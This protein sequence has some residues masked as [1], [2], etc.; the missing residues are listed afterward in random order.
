MVGKIQAFQNINILPS[1]SFSLSI[2]RDGIIPFNGFEWAEMPIP[3]L[4][5]PISN[6]GNIV[7][8]ASGYITDIYIISRCNGGS[9]NFTLSN[10]RNVNY[11]NTCDSPDYGF[12][13][14]DIIVQ[15]SALPIFYENVEVI[16]CFDHKNENN[17]TRTVK[18]SSEIY[19]QG[20]F[21]IQNTLYNLSGKS[22]QF[23][24]LPF[25]DYY[26][27]TKKN[28]D[29]SMVDMM[30]KLVKDEKIK[31]AS[32]YW[33]LLNGMFGS[34]IYDLNTSVLEKVANFG[35]NN[36]II[37]YC[38]NR[39]IKTFYQLFDEGFKDY[40]ISKTPDSIERLLNIFSIDFYDLYGK[41]CSCNTFFKLDGLHSNDSPCKR[42]LKNRTINNLGSKL[43]FEYEVTAGIP[44]LYN[45][46][47]TDDVEI[48]Y[49]T[50]Q[51]SLSTYPL[52]A[53]EEHCINQKLN[54]QCGCAGGINFDNYC[55]YEWNK[56]PQNNIIGNQILLKEEY[57]KTNL[58][59]TIT[60]NVWD[61]SIMDEILSF[62]LNRELS[63]IL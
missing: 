43:T 2:T 36:Q 61:D 9:V 44:F 60:A 6:C 3:F 57:D 23:D 38:H 25:Y 35:N 55:F 22:A 54:T 14:G 7:H 42:C 47:G 30:K 16:D 17:I 24:I 46:K 8:Y 28:E 32:N 56:T 33:N 26:K 39:K 20:V 51:N 62:T 12:I 29:R 48:I 18:L 63:A 10:L 52:S 21:S 40:K 1:E 53:M 50:L 13:K 27:L 15:Q 49:P 5:S 58:D 45:V 31:N 19:V 34:E 41:R 59:E 11:Q 4:V 37:D